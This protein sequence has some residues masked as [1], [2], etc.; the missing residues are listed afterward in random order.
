[1]K[2]LILFLFLCS[3]N[4]HASEFYNTL[5]KT[6]PSMMDFGLLK[7]ELKIEK[8]KDDISKLLKND[9]EF[10]LQ[11]EFRKS[12]LYDKKINDL[13]FMNSLVIDINKDKFDYSGSYNHQKEKII[14]EFD[15]QL[16]VTP[17][18]YNDFVIENYKFIEAKILCN[19]IREVI[20]SKLGAKWGRWGKINF[21]NKFFSYTGKMWKEEFIKDENIN[22]VV[23]LH[24]DYWK[25]EPLGLST[26]ACLGDISSESSYREFDFYLIDAFEE[27]IKFGE[28]L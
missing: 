23:R 26:T 12:P 16:R 14:L 18:T 25:D 4:L 3:F 17:M 13:D 19:G 28:S 22:L 27:S 15:I 5:N 1:M 21:F 6:S 7:I 9:I 20:Q 11:Q 24:W 2:K 10:A 8:E